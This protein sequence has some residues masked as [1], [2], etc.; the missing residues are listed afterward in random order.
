MCH[1]LRSVS[2]H[3]KCGVKLKLSTMG[4][5][6]VSLVTMATGAKNKTKTEEKWSFS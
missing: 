3:D 4:V 6:V 2:D 5:L 1:F